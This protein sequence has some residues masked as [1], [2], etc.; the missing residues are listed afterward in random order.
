MGTGTATPELGSGG[1]LATGL[2]PVV[3]LLLFYRR[4]RTRHP[5]ERL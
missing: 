5:E 1:L 4:R 2:L 3:G